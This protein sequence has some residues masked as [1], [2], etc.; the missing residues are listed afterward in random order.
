MKASGASAP[1]PPT[2][3][4]MMARSPSWPDRGY[5][6]ANQPPILPEPHTT[7]IGP[8]YSDD[9]PKH[10]VG[11]R[12]DGAQGIVKNINQVL[13]PYR[14]IPCRIARSAHKG[15]PGR[16]ACFCSALPTGVVAP[17]PANTVARAIHRAFVLSSSVSG[18]LG[19]PASGV[20][21]P[22][23]RPR[24]CSPSSDCQQLP[25]E[26]STFQLGRQSCSFP[27][28]VSP[29]RWYSKDVSQVLM[30][31]SI[32]TSWDDSSH[33][34]STPLKHPPPRFLARAMLRP[35]PRGSRFSSTTS[36]ASSDGQNSQPVNLLLCHL[37]GE[38]EQD[39]GLC[40]YR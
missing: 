31:C 4:A 1:H 8:A 6:P 9:V 36:R 20:M 32:T 30:A 40:S 22:T 28:P 13:T 21:R 12:G 33:M 37:V 26:H 17:S 7:P 38:A 11:C 5:A 39:V 27:D 24:G 35:G 10:F 23:L 34:A 29:S 2:R 19:P 3:S 18:S 16:A 25:Q 15:T 14:R